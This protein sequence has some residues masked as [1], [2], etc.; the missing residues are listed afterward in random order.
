MSTIEN[1][2]SWAD[3]HIADLKAGKTVQFRPHGRSMEPRITSGALCTV[4]PVGASPLK[5]GDIVL[6]VVGRSQYV[7]LV[8][9]VSLRRDE[10]KIGN[11]K[12]RV[13]GWVKADAIFGKLVRVEA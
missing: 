9:D 5:T 7:H 11:N 10:Y 1:G 2:K 3:Q 6:C 8:L 12:G 4:E 13:N